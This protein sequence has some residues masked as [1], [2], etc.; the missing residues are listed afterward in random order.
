MVMAQEPPISSQFKDNLTFIWET[1][2]MTWGALGRSARIL[3]L[4][5]ML[6]RPDVIQQERRDRNSSTAGKHKHNK[7]KDCLLHFNACTR[8]SDY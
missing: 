7:P 2:E 5:G 6:C 8:A 1:T 4:R 3:P